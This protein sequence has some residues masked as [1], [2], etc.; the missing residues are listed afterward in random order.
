MKYSDNADT[1]G[2]EGGDRRRPFLAKHR[3]KGKPE[4]QDVSV[5]SD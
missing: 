2:A 5:P 1:L 3:R 4:E